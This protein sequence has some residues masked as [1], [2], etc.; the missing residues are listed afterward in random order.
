MSC[1]CTISVELVSGNQCGLEYT[2]G[3]AYA[4]GEQVV[5]HTLTD[6]CGCV[7][8]VYINGE[9][10]QALVGDGQVISVTIDAP[11]CNLCGN[12]SECQGA[13]APMRNAGPTVLGLM[14]KGNKM[15]LLLNPRKVREVAAHRQAVQQ[16]NLR[17]TAS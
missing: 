1:D 6:P 3:V 4:I 11:R 12:T 16:R 7:D 14:R 10:D 2:D 5:S 15:R 9:E 17:G 13:F 8:K